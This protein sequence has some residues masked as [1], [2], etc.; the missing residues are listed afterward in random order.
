[1]QSKA[2]TV[3]AYLKE[4]PPD[5]RATVKAVRDVVL[6][7]IDGDIEEGMSYGMIGYWV[8]HRVFPDG[9]HCDPSQPLPYLGIA[10]QVQYISVYLMSAYMGAGADEQWIRSEYARRGRPI[11]MGKCCLR[12]KSLKDIDLEVLAEAIRRA[13]T[14]K[15]ID[16]YVTSVGPGAW[17]SKGS[18]SATAGAKKPA[19]RAPARKK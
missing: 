13:P 7:T 1:M 19:A 18:R 11:D 9:Y 4:L 5:R 3:A 10:S 2:K 16:S 12:F 6:A 17:K 14:K 15:Y 8:P